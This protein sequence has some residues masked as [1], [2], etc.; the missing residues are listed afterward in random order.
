MN[1]FH[2]LGLILF[3]NC[4]HKNDTVVHYPNAAPNGINDETLFASM[5]KA[6]DNKGILSLI[7]YRNDNIIA[8][9]YFGS[10][11]S[12]GI[13]P[14]RSVTKSV[15]SILFGLAK[16]M[17]Y[18]GD[19]NATVGDYLSEFLSP[20]DTLVAKVTIKNLLTMTGGFEW[21]ELLNYDDYND[22]VL[23]DAHFIYALQVPIIHP[24][25]THF[26]YTTPGCQLLS[27]IFTK[28]TG[29]TLDEYATEYFYPQLNIDGTRPWD[30][31][32]NG[33]N[34]GGVTLELKA[35]D[36]L[37]VGILMRDGGMYD[38][39]QVLSADWISGST[40]PHIET[41]SSLYYAS[42][43]GYLWW[44][45][46]NNGVDY[47]F[48]NGYGGQFIIVFPALN[49]VVVAQSEINNPHHSPNEQWMN[50]ASIIMND[51]LNSVE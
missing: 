19:L 37:K 39:T 12:E 50:T 16:D 46:D 9:E 24:P 38:G 27:A 18:V 3:L 35:S 2:L 1:K 17:G 10:N 44:L 49:M 31:D 34:Y 43:Y 40:A 15:T 11:T 42:H 33:Y 23:S 20:S 36:M 30:T 25:G 26:T 47:Y 51:I 32:H 6:K 28:A 7:V 8:E 4:C 5:E 41:F 13:H 48:A 14:V 29:M 22:W 45:G 21:E